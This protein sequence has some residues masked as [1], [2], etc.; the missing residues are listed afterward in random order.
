[1]PATPYK[2]QEHV[3][4]SPVLN[5]NDAVD[6]NKDPGFAGAVLGAQEQISNIMRTIHDSTTTPEQAAAKLA[7]ADRIASQSP[8]AGK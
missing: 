5:R 1:M 7:A 6:P 3:D 4:A 2:H 8:L